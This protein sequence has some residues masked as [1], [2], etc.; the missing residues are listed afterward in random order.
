MGLTLRPYQQEIFDSIRA[1][2]N[3]LVVLPTGLGKTHIALAMIEKTLKEGKTSLFLTPT[4]P[5]ARQHTQSI[6]KF[7]PETAAT[8]SLVTGELPNTRRAHLYS[9][10][11]IISTPQTIRNDIKNN[12]FPTTNTGLVVFD[13]AHRAV[14]GYSYVAIANNLPPGCISVALTASPGGDRARIKEVLN[15]LKI[16]NIQIK[17]EA[18]PH[19]QPHIHKLD[20]TW[21]NV[22]LSPKLKEADQLLSGMIREYTSK[23]SNAPHRPPIISKKNFILYGKRLQAM[24]H[25]AKYTLISYYYTLL[26]LL[27]MQELL[28]TQGPHPTLK[29]LEKLNPT[30]RSAL[31]ITRRPETAKIRQLLLSAGDHPKTTRL[32][33]LLSELGNRKIILFVQYRDQI[34]RIRELLEQHGYQARIFVGKRDG[35]TKKM[36]EETMDAFRRDEFQILVASSIGEEGLDIPAVDSVIFFEPI[37]SEIRSIQRRG[38]AGRFREG[39]VYVLVTKSTRDEHYFWASRKREQ[40]MKEILLSL[41]KELERKHAPDQP[42]K[43]KTTKPNQSTLQSFI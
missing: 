12:L 1:N 28:Q 43:E 23:F 14:G 33:K 17:T 8:T 38:R 24:R 37:P 11:I 9:S 35:F 29:Y 36:Q 31:A 32:L 3:T 13:E 21:L 10:K 5:L 34:N 15:N 18:D 19:I 42:K 2:G 26:H 25:P 30:S 41:Q 16:R 20:I 40:K 4:K 39:S 7:L 22:E 6:G 27:H